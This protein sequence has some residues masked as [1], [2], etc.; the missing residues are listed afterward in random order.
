MEEKKTKKE[1]VPSWGAILVCAPITLVIFWMIYQAMDEIL[2]SFLPLHCNAFVSTIIYCFFLCL[3][4]WGT[5]WFFRIISKRYTEIEENV[6][7]K[8]K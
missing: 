1:F 5:M 7:K 8:E 2:M 6:K 4:L 3:L